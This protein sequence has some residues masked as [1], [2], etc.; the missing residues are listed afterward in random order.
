M[1]PARRPG[2]RKR[3]KAYPAVQARKTPR[4]VVAAATTTLLPSHRANGWS[5]ITETKFEN[6]QWPGHGATARSR[7]THVG[8][9]GRSAMARL[10]PPEN[11]IETTQRIG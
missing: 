10:C 11:A 1:R 6:D 7:S 2:K 9:A 4:I 3:E 5:V 8:L